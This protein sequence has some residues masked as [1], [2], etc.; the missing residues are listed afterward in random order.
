MKEPMKF[1]ED[2]GEST[3]L[4]VLILGVLTL[5]MGCSFLTSI[6]EGFSNCG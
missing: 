6:V 1:L 3:C 4:L 5:L 2:N